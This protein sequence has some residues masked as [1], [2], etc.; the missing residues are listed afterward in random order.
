MFPGYENLR[1]NDGDGFGD[2]VIDPTKNNGHSDILV[3]P[4]LTTEDYLEYQ[5]TA[6]N[7]EQFTGYVIKVVATTT[8]QS[9]IPTFQDIR[10]LAFA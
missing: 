6:D 10:T 9:D 1:D 3:P 2:E 5:F 7:L 8:N 4:S